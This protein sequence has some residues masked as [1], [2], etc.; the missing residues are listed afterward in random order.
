MR[1]ELI[2]ARYIDPHPQPLSLRERGAVDRA[3]PVTRRV[4]GATRRG[5]CTLGRHAEAAR[6][7]EP[8]PHL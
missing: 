4:V 5:A 6:S 7:S 3:L 2:I 1:P 8:T